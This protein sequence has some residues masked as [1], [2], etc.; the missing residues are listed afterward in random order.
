[1]A[2]PGG[3][4]TCT[5]EES[6]FCCLMSLAPDMLYLRTHVSGDMQF[7]LGEKQKGEIC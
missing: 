5:W 3:C 1:M 7:H 2:C 6:I 4:S